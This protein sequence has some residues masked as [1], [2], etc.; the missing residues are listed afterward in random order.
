MERFYDARAQFILNTF[1]SAD[2]WSNWEAIL[3]CPIQY[4]PAAWW[5]SGYLAARCKVATNR[6]E[7]MGWLIRRWH[8][9]F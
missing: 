9:E 6:I 2:E 7:G 4:L 8:Q 5:A 3:L 1:G